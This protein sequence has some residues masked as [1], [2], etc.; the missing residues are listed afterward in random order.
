MNR[1]ESDASARSIRARDGA[2]TAGSPIIRSERPSRDELAIPSIREVGEALSRVASR[3]VTVASI[4]G[5]DKAGIRRG[6]IVAAAVYSF[7][8]FPRAR[9]ITSSMPLR[10]RD[11]L[12][13]VYDS[14][15]RIPERP[16]TKFSSLSRPPSRVDF[17][18][19]RNE[20]K[21]TPTRKPSA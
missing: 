17:A 3:K 12:A 16:R 5:D 10:E 15:L 18:R 4:V 7:L 14:Q 19:R 11:Y 1:H 21:I 6:E 8:S 20:M 9:S 13:F 2:L